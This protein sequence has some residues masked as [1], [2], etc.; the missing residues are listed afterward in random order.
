MARIFYLTPRAKLGIELES[1]SSV[2]PLL[3]TLVKD[4]LPTALPLE[5]PGAAPFE[6]GLD[7]KSPLLSFA[8]QE[9]E[10]HPFARN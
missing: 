2:A 8:D 10:G 1:V 7:E 5:P 9:T 4:T 6:L 3:G